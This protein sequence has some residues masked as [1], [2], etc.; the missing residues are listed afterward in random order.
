MKAILV[1]N[2]EFR[3]KITISRKLRSLEPN[4]RNFREIMIFGRNSKLFTRIN[5]NVMILIFYSVKSSSFIFLNEKV[6]TPTKSFLPPFWI[7]HDSRKFQ[8]F[9]SMLQFSSYSE[10]GKKLV[11]G[12][13][14]LI[15]YQNY[16]SIFFRRK[17]QVNPCKTNFR[18]PQWIWIANFNFWNQNGRYPLIKRLSFQLMRLRIIFEF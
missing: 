12:K 9:Y 5:F 11:W 10:G 3:P 4:E 17:N 8:N 13:K 16:F 6:F 2:F 18:T 14:L 1:N 7:I 15:F